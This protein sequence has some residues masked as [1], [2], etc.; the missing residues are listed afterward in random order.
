VQVVTSTV[1]DPDSTPDTDPLTPIT[2]PDQDD[3]SQATIPAIGD[4]KLTNVVTQPAQYV[5]DTVKFTVTVTNDGPTDTTGVNVVDKLPEGLEFVASEPSTGAYNPTTGVWTVGDMATGATRTLVITARVKKPGI[6]NTTAEVTSSTAQDKDSTPG[7]N[8]PTEDDQADAPV[9]TVGATLGDT[10][11]YDTDLDFVKDPGELGLPGVTVT[12]RWAGPNGSSGDGDDQDFVTTTGPDGTWS[13]TGLPTGHYQ[14]TVDPLTLPQ[15]ITTA[16]QDRDGQSSAHAT[17]LTLDG[18]QTIDDVDFAYVGA[19]RVG[20]VVFLDTNRNGVPDSGE[21]I[22]GVS[23]ALVWNGP[24]GDPGTPDDVEHTTVTDPEGRYDFPNLPAGKFR[25]E[26]LTGGLPAGVRNSVDPQGADDNTATFDLAAAE[27]NLALDFG[28]VGTNS[29]GDRVFSDING[30]GVQQPGEPG[31][32]GVTVTLEQDTNGDG[33]YETVVDSAPTAGNGSYLFEELPAGR[34]RATIT[35]PGG[36]DLTTPGTVTRTVSS[37]ETFLEADFGLEPPPPGTPGSIGDL[38]WDDR[39]G[40][41]QPDPGEPG[42]PGAKVT[43]WETG[44]PTGGP[45][46]PIATQTTG[47]DGTYSFANLPPGSYR[48]TVTPPDG[49]SPTTPVGIPVPLSAGKSV[50]TADFGFSKETIPPGTIG[51]RVWAD[52]NADGVQDDGEPGLADV[53]LTLRSDK[54]GDGVYETVAGTTKTDANGI[55]AFRDVSPGSYRVVAIAPDAKL[56]TVPIVATVELAAG[57]TV[58]TAD[59]GF[60][61]GSV[62]PSSIGDRIWMDSDHDGVQDPEEPGVNDVTVTLRSD[63][64]GDGTYD[65]VVTTTTTS[66]DGNYAFPNLPPGLYLVVVTPPDGLSPTVPPIVVPLVA[67]QSVSTADIGLAR[68]TPVPFDLEIGKAAETTPLDGEDM[69]WLFRVTNNGIAP[70]PASLTVT[71][72]LPAGLSYRSSSGAGWTCSA[73]GQTVTCTGTGPLARG[74]SSTFRIITRVDLATGKGLLNGARVAAG[75]IEI[76]ENNNASQAGI[77]VGEPPPVIPAGEPGTPLL[78]AP[79]P[80]A[81]GDPDP[82]PPT[83]VLPAAALPV[84]GSDIAPWLRLAAMLTMTGFAMIGAGRRRRLGR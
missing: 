3:E 47:T 70:S 84:T 78:P 35:P 51:D 10:V 54:D 62:P 67:G 6:L 36:L 19:G 59:F 9:T 49:F 73:G 46:R 38:V 12:A 16:T 4:V 26:V 29:I 42:I 34:Y 7:N 72:T 14:V 25:V 58:D 32:G 60:T 31:L 57:Q 43:L 55:Y 45:D 48:V 82:A 33:T 50:D 41:G 39:N 20:D 27:T 11:W 61:T 2:P 64:D 18:G 71:D 81:P 5:G 79:A 21:G 83:A 1:H 80:P 37:G 63:P 22:P 76:T 15:G 77:V 66:G 13:L 40:N 23:V 53:E 68:P 17:T 52:T 30:D 65:K 24:D 44:S 74:A 75:G 28:Y 8:V 69:T 56:P